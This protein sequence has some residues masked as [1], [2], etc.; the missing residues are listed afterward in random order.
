[1]LLGCVVLCC[2][3]RAATHSLDFTF[4]DATDKLLVAGD[5]ECAICRDRLAAAKQLPCG[6]LFHLPCLRAWLQQSGHDNF[7]CPICRRALCVQRSGAHAHGSAGGVQ[8]AAGAA[9]QQPQ[10]QW[11]VAGQGSAGLMGGLSLSMSYTN[12]SAAAGVVRQVSLEE[13]LLREVGAGFGDA[14]ALLGD[15][16]G[17]Q[18]LAAASLG[19]SD[20]EGFDALLAQ[21]LAASLQTTNMPSTQHSSDQSHGRDADGRESGAGM[22][23]PQAE[24]ASV[25]SGEQQQQQQ[26][27]GAVD[28]SCDVEA[29][30]GPDQHM[31]S[32][33]SW[34]MHQLTGLSCRTASLPADLGRQPQLQ[35]QVEDTVAWTD[36]STGG[37]T[38]CAAAPC[39][40]LA[41]SLASIGA[42]PAVDTPHSQS[43]QHHL[44]CLPPF[45]AV[46]PAVIPS[47]SRTTAM[48]P[49]I[50]CHAAPCCR[51]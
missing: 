45:M 33:S 32:D 8:G 48:C 14:E 15:A 49:A 25:G 22:A 47:Y 35:L 39:A 24:A 40:G 13:Q 34:G 10:Q 37:C 27:M 28:A 17:A 20:A 44:Y 18:L 50:L 38:A 31:C 1:M 9:R 36:P 2:V 23:A 30:S 26:D 12:L 42:A 43:W 29:A 7:N 21:A 19:S 4:P 6:H 41:R 51:S 5:S 11:R 3:H 46:F 16:A